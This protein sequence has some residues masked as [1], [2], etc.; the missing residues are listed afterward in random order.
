MTADFV[1]VGQ[2]LAGTALAWALLKCNARV[3]VLDRES[4]N[5]ASRVAAG[6]LTP[7]TGKRLADSWRWGEL[8]PAARAFYREREAE[9]GCNFFR[10]AP[11]AR[12][13]QSQAERERCRGALC[14]APAGFRAPLG[15]FEMPAARLDVCA[16]L[17]ASRE[18]F[19]AK[20][21]YERCDFDPGATLPD[22]TVV[23]CR[24]FDAR[25]D[26]WFGDIAWNAAKGEI[27]TVRVPDLREDRV[28]HFGGWLAPVGEDLYRLGATYSWDPL[29]TLITPEARAELE[30]KL[31]AVLDVPFEVV[32]HDAAVR[33]V[34]DAGKPALGTHPRNARV[35]FFNGLGS[36]G[37]LLAPFFAEQLAAHL[38]NG[39]PLDPEVDVRRWLPVR[40]G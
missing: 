4:G 24:G 26:P 5:R 11:A 12:L 29:N 32:G 28:I 34:I 35:A 33:P 20:G 39:G 21:V 14:E 10:E 3:R 17:D 18:A 23:F 2:G 31:R 37:S 40:A 27:L 36:K 38:C 1:I 8:F 9:L 13:F 19:R 22:A 25:E 15:A 6:L 7:I 30:A 16:Y